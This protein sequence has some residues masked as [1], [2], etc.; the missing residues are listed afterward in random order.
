MRMRKSDTRSFPLFKAYDLA[1]A[2]QIPNVT[3]YKIPLASVSID[4]RG[5]FNP[6]SNRY[7]V[8]EKGFYNVMGRVGAQLWLNP[9]SY[10][11]IG[12]IY[13]NGNMITTGE[14]QTG[15]PAGAGAAYGFT[16]VLNDLVYLNEKDYL[17]LYLYVS[18]ASTINVGSGDPI[19][20]PFMSAHKVG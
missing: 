7:G 10:S 11:I 14:Q 19:T 6:N 9:S 3:W 2:R 12:A 5:T 16:C 17:E 20:A 15:F 8:P 4:N 18:N 13:K 1:A